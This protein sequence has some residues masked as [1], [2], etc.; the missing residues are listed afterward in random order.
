VKFALAEQ[1]IFAE[2]VA[3]TVQLDPFAVKPV[4]E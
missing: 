1:L 3:E 4:N 2:K